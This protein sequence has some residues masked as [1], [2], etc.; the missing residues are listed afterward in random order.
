ML[1]SSTSQLWPAIFTFFASTMHCNGHDQPDLV[2]TWISCYLVKKEIFGNPRKIHNLL[3]RILFGDRPSLLLTADWKI[4]KGWKGEWGQKW[5]KK[6]ANRAK[7]KERA[8]MRQKR[9]WTGRKGGK[10][11]EW[12]QKRGEQGENEGKGKNEAKKVVNRVKRRARARENMVPS[13]TDTITYHND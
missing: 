3:K 13:L 10:G 5:G 4:G 12:G 6:V 8:R 1:I 9:W 2:Q 7:R 11:Q